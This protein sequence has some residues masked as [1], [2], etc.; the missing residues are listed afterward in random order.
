M[1]AYIALGVALGNSIAIIVLI[2]K[3][4]CDART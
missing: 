3:L 4:L 2:R 1:V